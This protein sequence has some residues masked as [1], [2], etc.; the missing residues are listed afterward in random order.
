MAAHVDESEEP[1]SAVVE[2]RAP[3]IADAN[4]RISWNHRGRTLSLSVSREDRYDIVVG[5]GEL[6][7]LPWHLRPVMSATDSED[8]IVISDDQVAPLYLGAVME[9]LRNAGIE[10]AQIVVPAGEPSKSVAVATRLWDDLRRLGVRRRTMLVALGGGV[11]C[12]LV[13]FVAATY[14]RGVP[15]VNVATSLMGQ[16]DGAI[17]GKVG[18]DHATGKNLIGAFYHPALVVI[19]PDCLATL[20]RREIGNGLAETV[21]VAVIGSQGL[22]GRLEALAAWLARRVDQEPDQ[23]LDAMDPAILAQLDPIILEAIE[24]K[25]DMLAPDPFEQDLRR[26]LNLGH[27]VGHALEAATA[28][29]TYRHGEAVAIGLATVAALAADDGRCSDETFRRLVALLRGLGLPTA[30]PAALRDKVWAFMEAVRLVRNGKLL[31]VVPREIGRCEIVDDI[32]LAQ[33]RAA[34]HRLEGV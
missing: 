27:S 3:E 7:R 29:Q 4:G 22:F 15:Y 25:L 8:V 18:V 21:K 2:T 11:M 9:R 24:I 13:G 33:Y 23:G 34:C 32:G 31:L 12:D 16:V 17:G 30:V 19:D 10:A 6:A 14:L 26:M 1:M 20:P 28:Y 5:R